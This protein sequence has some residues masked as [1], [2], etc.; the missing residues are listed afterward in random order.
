M[1]ALSSVVGVEL[2][3]GLVAGRADIR[4]P[5]HHAGMPLSI[6]VQRDAV[7]H[8]DGVAGRQQRAAR[9][10]GGVAEFERDRRVRARARRRSAHRRRKSARRPG[11]C[12]VATATCAGVLHEDRHRASRRRSP[13][14]SPRSIA[15]GPTP[16]RMLP[17]F[18]CVGDDRLVDEHLQ[19]QVVDVD[20]RRAR[21]ADHR[22]LAG[23]R[24]GAAHAVDLARVGR[25][26]HAQQE[27]V[28]LRRCRRAGRR[29]GNTR[30]SRCRRASSCRGWRFA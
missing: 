1:R 15:N 18:C 2:G 24:V 20:P 10:A 27:L 14:T 13:A 8:V 19:E 29:R 22:D 9:G 4:G 12:T 23:Q 17:Q 6:S 28:A 30:P 3:A 5:E 26:H 11:V 21:L 7:D 16:A 25:A